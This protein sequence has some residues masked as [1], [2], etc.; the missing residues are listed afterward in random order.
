M[1]IIGSHKDQRFTGRLPDPQTMLTFAW[2]TDRCPLS[3]ESLPLDQVIQDG[4]H[5]LGTQVVGVRDWTVLV[6]RFPGLVQNFFDF[7]TY[8]KEK[9]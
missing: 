5:C 1:H 8:L 6:V 4:E 7:F 9:N 2:V 3:L